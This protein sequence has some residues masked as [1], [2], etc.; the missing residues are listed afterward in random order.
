[1]FYLV[2]YLFIVFRNH[3]SNLHCFVALV[4][5]FAL[6]ARPLEMP[7]DGKGKHKHHHPS[8]Y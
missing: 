4:A 1:M 5:L 7:N 2:S 3:L 6:P 8:I